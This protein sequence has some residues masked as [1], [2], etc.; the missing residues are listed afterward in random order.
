MGEVE[1]MMRGARRGAGWA[2][3]FG[4]VLGAAS[5]LNRGAQPTAKV[6]MKGLLRLRETGAELSERVQ[7]LYAEAQAEY[8]S[9]LL[10]RDQEQFSGEAAE[11]PS[12]G[13][14]DRPM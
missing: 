9:E 4:V 2:L 1:E 10:A 7:D 3:G 6:A 13:A 8:A 11:Q 14:A 12:G 5:V